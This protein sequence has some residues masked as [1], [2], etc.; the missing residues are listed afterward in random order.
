MNSDETSSRF[1]ISGNTGAVEGA[2]VETL[3]GDLTRL[4]LH[5]V[6]LPS[7]DVGDQLLFVILGEIQ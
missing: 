6:R 2:D 7:H 1:E 5:G 4:L 3:G